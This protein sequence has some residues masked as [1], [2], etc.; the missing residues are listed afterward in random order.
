MSH[1]TFNNP[2]SIEAR[3]HLLDNRCEHGPKRHRTAKR[4]SRVKAAKVAAGKV[5]AA[6]QLAARRR[7]LAASR[8]YWS[9]ERKELANHG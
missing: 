2:K 3:Q 8:A 9:G 5:R 1:R 7:L 4:K 6:I